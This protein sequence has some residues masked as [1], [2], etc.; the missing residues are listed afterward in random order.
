MP[1]FEAPPFFIEYNNQTFNFGDICQNFGTTIL[2]TPL[3][4]ILESVSIAK[5][6]GNFFVVCFNY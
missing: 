4:A 3:I 5:S 2:V 6:F 1:P